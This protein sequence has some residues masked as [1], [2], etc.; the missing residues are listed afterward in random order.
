VLAVQLGDRFPYGA[1]WKLSLS[2]CLVLL[3]NFLSLLAI[4]AKGRSAV[5]TSFRVTEAGK[6]IIALL[7][8][9]RWTGFSQHFTHLKTARCFNGC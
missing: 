9:D 6:P 4:S 7:E 8:V 3:S 1:S 5:L 2:N